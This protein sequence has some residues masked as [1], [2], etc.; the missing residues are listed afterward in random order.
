[1]IPLL[2]NIYNV[3]KKD[4]D[5]LT[6]LMS[7]MKD[8]KYEPFLKSPS[9]K[10]LYSNDSMHTSFLNYNKGNEDLVIKRATGFYNTTKK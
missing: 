5:I 8:N 6:L 10:K 2:I 4:L 1:M 3:T 7:L 9:Y